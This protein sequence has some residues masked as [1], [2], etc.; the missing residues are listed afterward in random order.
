MYLENV[1]SGA[2]FVLSV[3][4]LNQFEPQVFL[5]INNKVSR[6]RYAIEDVSSKMIQ[7]LASL[8][9]YLQGHH[10]LVS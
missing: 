8:E 6:S 10:S 3:Q 4:A 7:Y 5:L 2:S 9:M 1:G